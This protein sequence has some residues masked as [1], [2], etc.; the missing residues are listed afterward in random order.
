MGDLPEETQVFTGTVT[1]LGDWGLHARPAA[2]LA[3]TSQGFTAEVRLNA[4]DRSADAKSILDILNLAAG[5]RTELML[6]CRG[7]DAHEAGDAISRLF[8]SGFKADV[9]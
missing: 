2:S 4:G 8:A 5:S 1:V 9:P 3:R 6:T 7:A